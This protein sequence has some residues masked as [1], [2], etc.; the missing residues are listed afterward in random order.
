MVPRQQRKPSSPTN[1][2]S[3]T[4]SKIASRSYQYFRLSSGFVYSALLAR[5]LALYP[6]VGSKF[7]AGGIHEFLCYVMVYSATGEL[8]WNLKHYGVKRVQGRTVLKNVNYLYFVATLHFH[9]DYEHAPVLKSRSY[10]LFIIA[11]SLTQAYCNWSRLF[12]PVNRSRKSM[13]WK[14]DSIALQPVLYLCE[15]YLLLLNLQ[16]PNFHSYQY[17]ELINKLI[18]IAFIPMALHA[19]RK[20]IALL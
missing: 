18:L 17:S 11:L 2:I 20:Q 12:K 6:L 15:F 3:L 8:F 19:Y 4:A 5:W 7:L 14:I 10:S 9:D 16:T 13:W 1:E